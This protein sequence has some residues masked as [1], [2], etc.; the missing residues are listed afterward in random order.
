M[1]CPAGSANAFSA[2]VVNLHHQRIPMPEVSPEKKVI[3]P[4]PKE[5]RI[6]GVA[7]RRQLP[8]LSVMAI[9]WSPVG[10]EG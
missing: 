8:V 1:P 3:R 4:Y 9:L 5:E 10:Q 6:P 7:M 2:L